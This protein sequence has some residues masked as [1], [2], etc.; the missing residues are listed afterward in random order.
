MDA[1]GL[2]IFI[3]QRQSGAGTDVLILEN[4]GG[5]TRLM[6]GLT[7]VAQSIGNE[8]EIKHCL[9]VVEKSLANKTKTIEL[10]N[11]ETEKNIE[12]SANVLVENLKDFMLSNKIRNNY[13]YIKV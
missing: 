10:L 3:G 8:Q 4:L 1:A 7:I 2:A 6:L 5:W 13:T 9:E 12:E 11:L